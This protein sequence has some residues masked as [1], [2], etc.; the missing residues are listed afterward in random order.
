MTQGWTTYAQGD[1]GTVLTWHVGAVSRDLARMLPG[2]TV[3]GA[4]NPQGAAVTRPKGRVVLVGY[5]LGCT[6]LRE[7][8]R[9]TILNPD[10]VV[11]IDG[12][13]STRG[14]KD[15]GVALEHRDLWRSVVERARR[16]DGLL[17]VM[18]TL[19][20]HRYT[21]DIKPAAE[22]Y[23]STG[24][25][26]E[27]ALGLADGALQ[28]EQTIVEGNLVVRSYPSARIDRPAHAAQLHHALPALWAD[29]VVPWLTRHR[30]PDAA[31][32]DDVASIE[33]DSGLP[34]VRL[35]LRA[36]GWLGFETQVDPRELPGP[37]HE[38]R[39]LEYSKHCRRGGELVGVT[40]L[41]VPIWRGGAPLPLGADEDPWCAALASATLLA[42]MQVGDRPPHGLR[43]SVRELVED[44]RAADTLEL[45]Q[46]PVSGE[47]YLPRP[48]D[49][50][51]DARD[52]GDPLLGGKGHVW[53]VLF[54][55]EAGDRVLGIGGNEEN[56][57]RLEWRQLRAPERRAWILYP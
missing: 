53:R 8:L 32:T 15:A 47:W 14:L 33:W 46:D 6:G 38:P 10:A 55:D 37:K 29:V 1:L 30:A 50:G 25:V 52:G 11:A 17:C 42:A 19:G 20:R 54:V 21:Q 41:G 45:A 24:R 4:L 49:L 40:A 23:A 35:G 26:I 7:T 57:I 13:H 51:I 28:V 36:L 5:S 16:S 39:I 48:G 3:L 9:S 56:R 22:A 27:Q 43:V 12:T 2:W 18:T 31:P 44:A 34:D